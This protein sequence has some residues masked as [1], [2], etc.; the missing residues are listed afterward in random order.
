MLKSFNAT[1]VFFLLLF[2]F[3]LFLLFFNL[4]IQYTEYVTFNNLEVLE[5]K[6]MA[7]GTL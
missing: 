5:L 6:L 7:N 4:L 3:L 2:W 1:F